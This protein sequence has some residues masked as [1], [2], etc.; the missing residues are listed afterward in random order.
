VRSYIQNVT[1]ELEKSGAIFH[2]F[3]AG[4]PLPTDVDIYWDARLTGGTPPWW[5]LKN[6]A[7]PCVATIHDGG[8]ELTLPPWEY[9]AS[10]EKM[11]KGM[12][13]FVKRWYGWR[14]WRGRCAALIAVSDYTRVEFQ[15][16]M[17]LQDEHI[18][19]LYHGVDDTLF[20]AS[21]EQAENTYFLHVSAFQPKK[22]IKRMFK[23]FHELNHVG[24]VSMLAVLPGYPERDPGSGVTLM[25]Q[26]IT[27]AELAPLYRQALAFVFPSLH[28]TFGMPIIEA[29]A[30]GCPVITSN[31][32]ACPETAGDAAMLVN[33]RSVRDIANAMQQ[34]IED[35]SLRRD[36]RE[37]GLKRA[38]SF[39]WRKSAE[40]HLKV[41]EEAVRSGKTPLDRRA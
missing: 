3:A 18:V 22:N 38:Q 28:E 27:H 14:S 17:G 32:T 12:R 35:D 26:P 36:L 1:S 24:S 37:K 16:N 30:C 33:P 19:P 10:M 25:R 4:D 7:K 29:M 31:V 39:T 40:A 15:R 21:T 41:F 34:L 6:A 5:K 9:Y 11:V 2:R 13:G 23:A 8:P 20:Y